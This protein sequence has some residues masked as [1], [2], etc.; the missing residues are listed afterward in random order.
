[1]IHI[2]P[3]L[4]NCINL[5]YIWFNSLKV[6]ANGNDNIGDELLNILTEFSPNSLTNIGISR[7]WRYSIDVFEQFLKSCR[8]RTLHFF[9]LMHHD[10]NYITKDHKIIVRKYI[11]EGVILSSNFYKMRE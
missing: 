10:K 3:L 9:Q 1:M 7:G 2:K 4:L 11:K 5:E 6:S 8:E